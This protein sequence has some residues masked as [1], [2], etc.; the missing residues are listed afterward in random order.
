MIILSD[1]DGTFLDHEDYS[2]DKSLGALKEF[3][4]KNGLIGFVTSKTAAEV[5]KLDGE[6]KAVGVD[7]PIPFIVENGC[8]IYLPK[9]LVEGINLEEVAKEMA[10]ESIISEKDGYWVIGFGESSY[11]QM[12]RILKEEIEPAI[13]KGI[14]G[15]GDMTAEELAENSGL[16]PEAANLAQTREF[17]EPYYIVDS[18]DDD[19]Q[20]AREI[21]ER[22]GLS[23]HKGGRYAHISIPQDKGK[24]AKLLLK[25]LEQKTS[26]VISVGI[27]DAENDLPLI[28]V[29]DLGYLVKGKKPIEE[30]LPPHVKRIEE[31]G[32]EGFSK[33]VSIELAKEN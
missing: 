10:P 5:L 22:H 8:G 29:C 11:S 6:L 9:A 7:A 32:P 19:Y 3:L 17:D 4:A 14:I 20:K 1:L 2:F 26:A 16:T 18:T 21:T 12:R 31:P 24:A 15:F 30:E 25:I 23:Y 33:V 27:G 28:K 13:G